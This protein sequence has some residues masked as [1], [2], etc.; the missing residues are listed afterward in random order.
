VDDTRDVVI[1]DSDIRLITAAF[2]SN[3][4]GHTV[5]AEDVWSKPVSYLVG[6]RDTF[7]LK[8]PNSHW[9]KMIPLSE[10]KGYFAAK[11]I[12]VTEDNLMC[13]TPE[14]KSAFFADSSYNLPARKVREDFKLRSTFF[15]VL[16]D[17]EHVRL[18]G[19]G[20]G[21]GV[22]LCQ[23]GAMV[24]A[25]YG[26]TYRDIIHYYYKDVHLIPRDYIRFF[27]E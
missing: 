24:M 1:V 10:W 26:Y 18:I 7:C 6:R 19:K 17:G 27:E 13:F 16:P 11:N 9:E 23:E 21:H 2:H 12:L 3:C 8:M 14:G 4:G 25:A 20:F 5:N 15:T 22:G